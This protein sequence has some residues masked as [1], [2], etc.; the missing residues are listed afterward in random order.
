M[1]VG[2]LACGAFLLVAGAIGSHLP[3]TRADRLRAPDRR[4]DPALDCLAGLGDYSHRQWEMKMASALIMSVQLTR[5]AIYLAAVIAFGSVRALIWAAVV[6]GVLQ[7]GVLW[8]YLQSRF[9]LLAALRL[10]P[11]AQP[12]V[13]RR[14]AG[15]GRY[16]LYRADRPAQLLRFQPAGRRSLRHLRRGDRCR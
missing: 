9:G 11:H 15:P 5:T 4:R 8:W 3:S 13:L 2:S 7:T 1:V 12:V 10:G 6:Q 14:A 16:T